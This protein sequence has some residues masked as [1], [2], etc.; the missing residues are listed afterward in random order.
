MKQQLARESPRRS[1]TFTTIPGPATPATRNHVVYFRDSKKKKTRRTSLIYSFSTHIITTR[2]L[3][4]YRIWIDRKPMIDFVFLFVTFS[5]QSRSWG[6]L[7][8]CGLFLFFSEWRNAIPLGHFFYFPAKITQMLLSVR[9]GN[10]IWFYRPCNSISLFRLL[11]M[12][13]RY[14]CG[15][16]YRAQAELW[17]QFSILGLSL[18]DIDVIN[19]V[20]HV[21]DLLSS[22]SRLSRLS[23][24]LDPAIGSIIYLIFEHILISF[25]FSFL[26][27][28][29]ALL[30]PQAG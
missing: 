21:S 6:F 2:L 4:A 17:W 19:L 20:S 10:G 16:S 1:S 13:G 26:F 15:S 8:A 22:L 25:D 5:S 3:N 30:T 28:F 23:Q 14:Y 24:R 11:Q 18:N 12:T 27:F 9:L 29:F 7:L